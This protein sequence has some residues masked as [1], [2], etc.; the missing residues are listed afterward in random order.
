[1]SPGV[2]FASIVLCC[3]VRVLFSYTAEIHM[4]RGIIGGFAA[5]LFLL[6]TSFTLGAGH[7]DI[8]DAAMRGD[9]AALRSLIQQKADINAVQ[10]DGAT[11]VHWAVYKGDAGQPGQ[12]QPAPGQRVQGQRGQRGGQQAASP[13]ARETGTNAADAAASVAED[14]DQDVIV[15]GLVG[16]GG[17]GLT[18]LVLAARK[19]DIES[20]K[21]LLDRGAER[22]PGQ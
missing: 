8:A 10:I 9:K 4:T 14:N 21:L 11:G 13:N 7:T 3:R 2:G 15:A 22:Q 20:A 12:G 17:G 18:A 5:A 1:M 16:T 6:M 19:G